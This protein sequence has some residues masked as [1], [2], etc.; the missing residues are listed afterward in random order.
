MGFLYFI[1]ATFFHTSYNTLTMSFNPN[2]PDATAEVDPNCPSFFKV[3]P[4]K[5]TAATM[6]PA[7]FT[8]HPASIKTPA[9]WVKISMSGAQVPAQSGNGSIGSTAVSKPVLDSYGGGVF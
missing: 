5:L 7:S 9:K 4:H 8:L 1:V 6:K 3:V 2:A